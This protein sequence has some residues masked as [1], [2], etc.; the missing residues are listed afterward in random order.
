[1]YFYYSIQTF[2]SYLGMEKMAW[3]IYTKIFFKWLS[4]GGETMR[5]F[6]NILV[7]TNFLKH[8]S[9]SMHIR[10]DTWETLIGEM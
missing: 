7:L 4:L 9:M 6:V 5:D 8:A 3:K 2:E 1:M 10:R